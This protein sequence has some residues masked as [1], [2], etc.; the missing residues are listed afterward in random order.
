MLSITWS[1]E[2][3]NSSHEVLFSII[4]YP[5]FRI[6]KVEPTYL[7]NEGIYVKELQLKSTSTNGGSDNDDDD[8]EEEAEIL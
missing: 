3:N 5:I 7:I 2:N 8:E 6:F 4:L 1:A